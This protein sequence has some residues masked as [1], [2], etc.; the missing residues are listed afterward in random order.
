MYFMRHQEQGFITVSILDARLCLV[1]NLQYTEKAIPMLCHG[2]Q[3]NFI[4]HTRMSHKAVT[5][6]LELRFRIQF[7]VL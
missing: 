3:N 4:V 2:L 5:V 6:F 1:D 7:R